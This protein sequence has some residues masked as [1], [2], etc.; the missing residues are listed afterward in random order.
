MKHQGT[1]SKNSKTSAEIITE[2]TGDSRNHIF[3]LIRL[4]ELI[5]DLLDKVDTEQLA[6][7]AAIELS[8]LSS[9][10]TEYGSICNGRKRYKSCKI[11]M[12]VQHFVLK[13]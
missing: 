2:Q 6:F 8:Y 4:T 12:K 3:R 7:H 9:S 11:Y 1:K 5:V 10:R 13:Y